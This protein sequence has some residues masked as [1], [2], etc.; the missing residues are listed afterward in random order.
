[1]RI[2]KIKRTKTLFSIIIMLILALSFVITS[3]V[4]A[5]SEVYSFSV[6]P[7]KE[8]ILLN[9]GD[10]YSSSIKVYTT[11]E[12]STDIKYKISVAGYYVD[13]NYQNIFEECIDRCDMA[14]WITIDSPTEGR[15]SP[16][17]QTIVEYT[18]NVPKDIHGGGQYASIIVEGE[19]WKDDN[20]DNNSSDDKEGIGSFIQEEKR[21]AY[22]IYAEV[23]G[24]IIKKGE[25]EDINVPSFLIS[26]DIKGFASVKNSGNVH[27]DATYKLQVF[28]LFSDEEI[29]TNEENP[30]TSTILPD[31]TRYEETAWAGTPGLGIFNVVYTVEFEG[32]K[33]QVS[34]IVIKCPIWLLFLIIFIIVSLIIW[35]IL[36]IRAR[37]NGGRKTNQD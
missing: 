15:L 25:I 3:K 36:R 13:E 29:Y 26:G 21:I 35:I 27:S 24:N 9:P 4:S 1:M 11:T 6:S 22:T 12:Y 5:A 37:S 8:K 20:E 17:E 34:K 33:A 23:S 30:D 10:E 16:G 28:P 31:R 18:I 14:N 7:M 19:P 2:K 32:A